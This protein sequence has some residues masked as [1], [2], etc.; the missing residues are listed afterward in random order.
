MTT[1]YSTAAAQ[2]AT[3]G[4]ISGF[5]RL[6]GDW[7]NGFATYLV[8]REAIKALRTM[9]DRELRDIGIH[10][11]HIEAAVW[12]RPDPEFGRLR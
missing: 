11:S 8:R 5:V 10:R 3:S 7:A 2:P 4:A 12:G 9:N 1:I 6:V